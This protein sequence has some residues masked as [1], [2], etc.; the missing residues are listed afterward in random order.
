M[1]LLIFL[2]FLLHKASIYEDP[3]LFEAFAML[4][5]GFTLFVPSLP[6]CTAM[7]VSAVVP[8]NKNEGSLR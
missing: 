5:L 6:S 1:S 4:K 8:L 3:V 2:D 7:Y